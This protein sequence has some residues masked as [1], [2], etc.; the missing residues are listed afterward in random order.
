[1]ADKWVGVDGLRPEPVRKLRKDVEFNAGNG[2]GAS[3][4]KGVD[5]LIPEREKPGNAKEM[6]GSTLHNSKIRPA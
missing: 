2:G 5:G 6:G 4:W 3:H 1:M